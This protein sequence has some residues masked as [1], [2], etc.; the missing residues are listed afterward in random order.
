[1]SEIINYV[2]SLIIQHS[3]KSFLHYQEQENKRPNLLDIIE[4]VEKDTLHNG[5]DIIRHVNQLVI[6]LKIKKVKA[7]FNNRYYKLIEKL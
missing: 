4:Y 5:I 1:M 6:T 3:I 7:N 2:D